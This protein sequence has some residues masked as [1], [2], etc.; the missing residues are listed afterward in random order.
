LKLFILEPRKFGV[1]K[2]LVYFIILFFLLRPVARKTWYAL[3]FTKTKGVVVYFREHEF[4]TS[5]GR[6]VTEYP[7]VEFTVNQQ[8]YRCVGSSFQKEAVN[9]EQQL[10]VIYDPDNIS[11]AYVYTFLGYWGPNVAYL[12]PAIL[13]FSLM[14]LGLDSVPKMLTLKI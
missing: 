11:H 10:P 5:R 1:S 9:I 4:Y 3:T 13:L 6:R 7:V 12:A 8:A 2:Y 14:F